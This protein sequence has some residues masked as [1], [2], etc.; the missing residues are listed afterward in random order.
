MGGGRGWKE[1]RVRRREDGSRPVPSQKYTCPGYRDAH[2]TPIQ[3]PRKTPNENTEEKPGKTSQKTNTTL[4]IQKRS[5]EPYMIGSVD[6][7]WSG[8]VSWDLVGLKVLRRKGLNREGRVGT[9]RG[10]GMGKGDVEL[11]GMGWRGW[12]IGKLSV[13]KGDGEIGLLIRWRERKNCFK[14]FVFARPRSY[15]HK[16]NYE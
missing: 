8:L 2:I 13:E 15:Q 12:V 4:E 16:Y 11:E 6:L 9:G 14:G 10:E 7:G 5:V 1:E 3:K